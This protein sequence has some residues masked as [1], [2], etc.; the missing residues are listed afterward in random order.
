MV[1]APGIFIFALEHI[2]LWVKIIT[3]C[4]PQYDQIHREV[5]FIHHEFFFNYLNNIVR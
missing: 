5:E 1:D 3:N 2:N 4:I